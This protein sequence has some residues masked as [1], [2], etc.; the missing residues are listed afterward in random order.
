MAMQ[1]TYEQ[2]AL[3]PVAD[4]PV[5]GTSSTADVPMDVDT[6]QERGR[7]RSAEEEP[8]EEGRKKAKTGG[9]TCVFKGDY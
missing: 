6:Q 4:A 8:A 5:P 2:Q 1:M 7:K 3:Q 9:T